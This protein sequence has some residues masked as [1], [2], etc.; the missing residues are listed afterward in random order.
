MFV[1]LNNLNSKYKDFV[2]RILTQLN[3]VLNFDKFVTLFYKK[4]RLFKKDIKEIIMIAIIKKYH[5]K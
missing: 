4:N 2:Y 5:K 1:L 3:D